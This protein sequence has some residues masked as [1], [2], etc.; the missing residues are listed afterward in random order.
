MN[1]S[2]NK[3][4][5]QNPPQFHKKMKDTMNMSPWGTRATSTSAFIVVVT[6]LVTMTLAFISD[7]QMH[8]FTVVVSVD[9]KVVSQTAKALSVDLQFNTIDTESTM[10]DTLHGILEEGDEFINN[11]ETTTRTGV[12]YE[13]N[14]QTD[15]L[16]VD[17]Q[18]NTTDIERN[19]KVYTHDPLGATKNVNRNE[20]ALEER[21]IATDK[22]R[23]DEST[24]I[25]SSFDSTV[26]ATHSNS[27][28]TTNSK[29]QPCKVLVENA[30]VTYHWETLES[31]AGLYPI[32]SMDLPAS[33]N[34]NHLI[35]DFHVLAKNEA[36][37]NSWYSYFK[38]FMRGKN[39]RT[40]D[41]VQ[42]NNHTRVFGKAYANMA[43]LSSPP[44]YDATIKASCYCR[45]NF[46]D[47]INNGRGRACVFHERC[48]KLVDN[49]RAVWL[50][51]HHE[52][53]YIPTLLPPVKFLKR[54]PNSTA[55]HKLCAVGHTSRRNYGLLKAFL[56]SP[57]GKAAL[58][59]FKF[60]ILG[61]G[62]FP[63][64]LNQYRKISTQ[65]QNADFTGFHQSVAKCDAMLM[66]IT[67]K[68]LQHYFVSPT[69]L[70]KLS[71]SFPLTI[72]YK[73][74]YF[75]HE[76]LHEL[77][78]HELPPGIPFAT[79]SDDPKTF[80]LAMPNFLDQLDIYYRR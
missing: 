17:L 21:W 66:L 12:E 75:V 6:V 38:R 70:L 23:L 74:P 30:R 11:I 45:P 42:V 65:E 44:R 25:A 61:T 53:Y 7:E 55:P 78:N 72:A 80:R 28:N 27:S 31:A 79:H 52:N 16:A 50:S 36:K 58:G 9:P 18:V 1:Q 32:K 5:T 13:G 41:D 71:G 47:W 57:E 39:A 10:N 26:H 62:G 76:E 15:T 20:S 29:L 49:P 51:P 8:F 64:A 56:D 37:F 14:E 77:Y 69:S 3:N 33:C 2:V 46:I 67:K 60:H 40:R 19:I 43:K 59:R 73:M 34:H 35:F 48:D 22:H 24:S 4:N 54:R 68:D 63:K